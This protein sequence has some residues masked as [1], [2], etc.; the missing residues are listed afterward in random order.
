MLARIALYVIVFVS[1]NCC[2]AASIDPSLDQQAENVDDGFDPFDIVY[3]IDRQNFT[4]IASNQTLLESFLE[5]QPHLVV[6]NGQTS[7]AQNTSDTSLM[8]K[9]PEPL[10]G[11]VEIISLIGELIIPLNPFTLGWLQGYSS[12][13]TTSNSSCL[14]LV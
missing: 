5:D 11:V 8:S 1:F 4:D 10:I 13:C 12:D 9:L 7:Q 2:N 6:V 3:I 14:L